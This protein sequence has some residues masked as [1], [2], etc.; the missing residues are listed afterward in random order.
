MPRFVYTHEWRTGDLVFWDNRCALH[1]AT[2]FD[3]E[4]FRR[5]AWRTT[6][7]GEAAIPVTREAA[8]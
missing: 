8:E 2:L 1:S 4:K 5:L 3:T 7:L 6:V